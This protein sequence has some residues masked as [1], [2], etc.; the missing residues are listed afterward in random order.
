MFS[1]LITQIE[2][3]EKNNGFTKGTTFMV[4]QKHDAVWG[5]VNDHQDFDF[6]AE[7]VYHLKISLPGALSRLQSRYWRELV[8]E[9]STYQ[10]SETLECLSNQGNFEQLGNA[11]C[12][13]P[14]RSF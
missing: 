6:L 13:L 3:G 2:G 11:V 10:A 12:F 14:R 9:N 7:C 5:G 4:S 8:V 1:W